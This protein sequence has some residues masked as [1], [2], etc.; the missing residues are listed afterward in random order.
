MHI[1]AAMYASVHM[2]F[3]GI[4]GHVWFPLCTAHRSLTALRALIDGRVQFRVRKN[5]AKACGPGADVA[6]RERSPGADVAGTVA[7]S[8]VCA[9]G[10]RLSGKRIESIV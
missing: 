4:C 1:P 9:S 3:F 7:A 10:V 5:R 6:N 2:T 8:R